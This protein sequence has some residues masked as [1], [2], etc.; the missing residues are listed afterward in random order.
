[1]GLLRSV[2]KKVMVAA[3]LVVVKRIVMRVA[4]KVKNR[5]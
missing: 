3:A 1:M 5:L 2:A 4:G